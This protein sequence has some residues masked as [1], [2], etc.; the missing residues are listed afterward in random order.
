MSTAAKPAI[1]ASSPKFL[2]AASLCVE[3][4]AEPVAVP[5]EDLVVPEAAVAVAIQSQNI[6]C[7]PE[8]G[9]P[10]LNQM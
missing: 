7:S 8:A 3:V 5:E 1:E 10:Y 9:A 6:I 4:A 2:P